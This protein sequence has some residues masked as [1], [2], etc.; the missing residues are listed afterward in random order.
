MLGNIS[1]I[2]L[3]VGITDSVHGRKRLQRS[4]CMP[5]ALGFDYIESI[6]MGQLRWLLPKS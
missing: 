2:G 1:R 4:I 5:K 6:K 3:T